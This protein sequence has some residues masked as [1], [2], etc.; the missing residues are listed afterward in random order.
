[1]GAAPHKVVALL[2]LVV[3]AGCVWFSATSLAGD[4]YKLVARDTVKTQPASMRT[5]AAARMATRLLPWSAD[6]QLLEAQAW[7]SISAHA[8]ARSAQLRALRLA[9]ADWQSWQALYASALKRNQPAIRSYSQKMLE[10]LAPNSDAMNFRNALLG[11]AYWEHGSKAMQAFWRGNIIHSLQSRPK[12]LLYRV[13][14]INGA[15][16]MCKQV[17]PA[18]WQKRYREWCKVAPQLRSVCASPDTLTPKQKGWC[19]AMETRL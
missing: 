17:P 15:R 16:R 5:L 12:L 7:Q 6:A 11:L 14:Q 8:R 18:D 1:M 13:Y 3:V 19:Q 4:V 9:P 10:Q 2:L